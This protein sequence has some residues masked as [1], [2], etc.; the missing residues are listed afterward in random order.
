MPS[1]LFI[2]GTGRSGT[3]LLHRLLADHPR[4][5]LTNEAGVADLVHFVHELAAAP[6]WQPFEWW[7]AAPMVVPGFVRPVYRDALMPVLRRHLA[8]L[9]EEFH[10]E[11]FEGRDIAYWGDKL[12]LPQTVLALQDVWPDL[13]QVVIVRDPRDVFC[14]TRSYAAKERVVAENPSFTN[15]DVDSVAHTWTNCYHALLTYGRDV[16][17]LRYEDLVAAPEARAADVLDWLGLE[18]HAGLRDPGEL[19]DHVTAGSPARSVGRWR[20]ELT[21]DEIAGLESVCGAWMDRF[22]YARAAATDR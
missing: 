15:V 5:A 7:R 17:L 8:G 12:P 16:H 4:L 18:P 11:L 21:P 2:T 1:P 10:A 6:A 14:S 22:G 3:T 13:R 19:P 9:L 20:A